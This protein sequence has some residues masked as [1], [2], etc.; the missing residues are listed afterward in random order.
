[1][2]IKLYEP[3]KHEPVEYQTLMWNDHFILSTDR[4][5]PISEWYIFMVIPDSFEDDS[6][7]NAIQ[8]NCKNNNENSTRHFHDTQLVY[9]VQIINVEISVEW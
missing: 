4:N 9:R 7:V 6:K 3:P 2:E 1:M 8:I 5:N